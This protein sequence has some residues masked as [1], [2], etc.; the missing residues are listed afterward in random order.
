ML[1][2][3]DFG[4]AKTDNPLQ[5]LLF[6]LFTFFTSLVLMNLLIAIMSDSYERVQANAAAADARAL[7]E[8]ILE[9][10]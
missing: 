4:D 1:A 10:E 2:F 7:A 3:G 6:A 9:M 8:M 5:L